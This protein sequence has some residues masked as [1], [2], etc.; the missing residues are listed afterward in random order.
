MFLH[1]ATSVQSVAVRAALL[2]ASVCAL[3]HGQV[4]VLTANYDN[5]RTNSNLSE[6]VLN[7]ATVTSKAFGK[8]GTFAVDGQL[9]AQPLYAPGVLIR[10][11]GTR[12]VVY[13]ATMH[14]SVYALDADAPQ[15]TVPLWTVNLGPA[16]PSAVFNF[17]DILP[18]VG[19]LSTPVI[20]PV[21]GVLYV[22]ANT[23]QP[24]GPVFQLHA[25][26]LSDGS[27][28]MNGPVFVSGNTQGTGLGATDDGVLPFDPSLHLQRPGLALANGTVY[29]SFGSHA[30]QGNFHG[31]LIGYDALDLRRQTAVLTTSPNGWGASVWQAGRAPAVDDRG[32]LFV[33]TGNGG[34]DGKTEFGETLLRLSG[35]GDDTSHD[36]SLK[37]VD[38]FTPQSLDTLNDSDWDFGSSGVM[39]VP[40]TD[41]LLAGA[42]SGVMYVAHTASLGHLGGDTNGAV[43]GVQVNQWGLFDMALW[44]NDS[45]P[46][47]YELEPQN[48]LRAFQIAQGRLGATELSEFDTT[49][50][51]GGIAV[52]ANGGKNGTGIV[53]LT[54]SDPATSGNPGTLHALDAGN[55]SRE[56]WSS[57]TLPDRDA[58]G[59]FAK[60]VAPTVANGRVYVATFSNALVTYGLLSGSSPGDATPQ[61]TS[62]VNAGSLLGDAVAPGE[63]V[64]VFGT[65]LGPAQPANQVLDANGKVGTTLAG[66]Q[67]LFNGVPAP[68]LYS[69]S[70][71][72]EAVAPFS[73]SGLTTQVQVV[74]QGK[75]SNPVAVSVTAAAP[76]LFSTSGDGGG[77]GV[78]NQDGS[79]NDWG[80]PAPAGSIVV[81]YATGLGQMNPAG[82]DGTVNGLPLAKVVQPV[83]VYFNGVEGQIL[84]AGAAPGMVAGVVQI[85]AVVPDSM[86]GNFNVQVIVK[87]GA[88]YSPNGLT[89]NVQ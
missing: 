72:L 30:D 16:I 17:S 67:V 5:A 89:V 65:N 79:I 56:L 21:R 28:V 20:D 69:S 13:I 70:T 7:P 26:S 50:F 77:F 12:N 53:W 42:K 55:I 86:A 46:I 48:A 6:T 40:G 49:T 35:Q 4:N 54:T 75:I 10:G 34:F 8:V 73:L 78:V 81:M 58:M 37:I 71:Q 84:Y 27:E 52:S 22:V 57:A 45:G 15:S 66:T 62:V 87:A 41:I 24:A 88:A 1:R 43:Q 60:F 19:I 76:A 32:N 83:S 68:L 63:V 18:E 47:V 25:L 3:A 59:R 2:T 33:V 39:L 14:N 31:W 85:N 61:V 74:S 38:W 29:L 36:S 11:H 82:Q 64:S 80:N 23:L 51:F 9:Y 44:K